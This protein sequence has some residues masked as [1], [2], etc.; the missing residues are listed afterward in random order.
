MSMFQCT[1]KLILGGLML[2]GGGQTNLLNNWCM[3]NIDVSTCGLCIGHLLVK[4][5]FVEMSLATVAMKF[6][7]WLI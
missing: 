7:G 5:F 2:G 3:K 1:V 4:H 6:Q